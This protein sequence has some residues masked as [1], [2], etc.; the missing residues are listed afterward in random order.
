MEDGGG[1]DSWPLYCG[2][3]PDRSVFFPCCQLLH[4]DNNIIVSTNLP[5]LKGI[6]V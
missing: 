1:G 3:K 5:K 4:S 2:E 6:L